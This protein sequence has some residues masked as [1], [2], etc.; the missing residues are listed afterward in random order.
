[1]GRAKMVNTSGRDIMEPASSR[2]SKIAF[3]KRHLDQLKVSGQTQAAYCREHGLKWYQLH[4]WRRKLSMTE[5]PAGQ[6]RLVP[7]QPASPIQN[8]HCEPKEN[9]QIELIHKG[10][11]IRITPDFDAGCLRQ[12][13]RV[14]TEL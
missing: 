6:L 8:V 10:I 12:A 14:I 5:A 4:Y 2:E 7:L 3:W 1:M 9:G 13:L 11:T